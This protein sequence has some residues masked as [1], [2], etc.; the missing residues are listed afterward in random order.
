MSNLAPR[1]FLLI[2]G[3]GM[4]LLGG[5]LVVVRFRQEGRWHSAR[6]LF[7]MTWA[8]LCVAVGAALLLM[9]SGVIDQPGQ[10]RQPRHSPRATPEFPTDR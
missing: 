2:N 3:V 4:L 8:L 1:W 7:G 6:K 5:A 9:A 10:A